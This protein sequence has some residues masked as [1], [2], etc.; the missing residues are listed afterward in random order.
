MARSPK[1]TAASTG[2]A[3]VRRI[4]D[5]NERIIESARSTSSS[6]LEA[7]EELL[8]NVASF[9]EAAGRRGGEWVTNFGKAQA[10]LTRELAKAYPSAARRLTEQAGEAAGAAA[11][12]ARRVPGVALTEG[13]TKGA[14]ASEGDLPIARYDSLNAGEIVRR[15]PRLSKVKLGEIDAYERKH[16][17]RKTVLDKIATLRG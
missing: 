13:E 14:L 2:E 4:R 3:T 7:Y 10:R 5:L 1:E 15:L 12:Q 16:R 11:R 9:Q 6:S 8:T 17:N